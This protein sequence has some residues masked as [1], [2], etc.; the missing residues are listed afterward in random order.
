LSRDWHDE[1]RYII[2]GFC[3]ALAA[4]IIGIETVAWSQ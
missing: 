1:E 2:S 4:I 3:T